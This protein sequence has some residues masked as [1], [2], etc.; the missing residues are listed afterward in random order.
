VKKVRINM[1]LENFPFQVTALFFQIC[2]A[3]LMHLFMGVQR[4]AVSRPDGSTSKGF[5]QQKP[6][7]RH[8]KT[9]AMKSLLQAQRG[10]NGSMT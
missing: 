10:S 5:L 3:A 6:S 1:D 4:A 7:S 2:D 8:F 9:L